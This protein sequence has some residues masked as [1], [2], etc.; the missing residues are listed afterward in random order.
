MKSEL[1]ESFEKLTLAFGERQKRLNRLITVLYGLFAVIILTT[2][3]GVIL[4]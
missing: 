4:T 2:A 3:L 1:D